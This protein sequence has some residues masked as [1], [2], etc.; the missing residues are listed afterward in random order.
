MARRDTETAEAP[1]PEVV[2]TDTA[3]AEAPAESTALAAEAKAAEPEVDYSAFNAAVVEALGLQDSATGELPVAAFG[4]VAEAYRNLP[5]TKARNHAKA[6]LN[7]QMK[8]AMNASDL[9]KARGLMQLQEHGT[10]AKASSSAPKAEKAPVDPTEGYVER[11]V[12]LRLAASLI[13]QPE[14]LA[15]DWA[16]R[17]KALKEQADTQVDAYKA[18]LAS[19]A[20]D[21]VEPEG[22]LP[23]VKRAF[24][25]A[26]GGALGSGRSK[27]ST[28]RDPSAPR[29]DIG[30]HISEAFADKPSGTFLTVADIRS[31]E[32]TEYG[33]DHPSAGAISARLKPKGGKFTL[34]GITPE[35]NGKAFGARKI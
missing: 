27:S 6:L 24:K 3:A 25:L 20:E 26:S 32:S 18:Y 15:A 7:S 17:V 12:S 9:P 34:T 13:E 35:S 19:E 1:A 16:D 2:S 8:D 11:Q 10:V 31:F 22:I 30:K 14:G 23:V 21:K 29:R 28:P 33:T 4:P 5:S